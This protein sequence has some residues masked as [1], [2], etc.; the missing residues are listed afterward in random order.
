MKCITIS[1]DTLN[2][3]DSVVGL[4]LLAAG[5]SVP[6]AVS[7]VIVTKQGHGAM[8]ISN[9]IGSNTFD[10]L[11]C[12]GIPW[13]I[14]AYFFPAIVDNKWVVINSTGLS[15]STISLLSSLLALYFTL[16]V[17]KF[18]LDWKVGLVC[19]LLYTVF[20]ILASLIELNF[21]FQVNL[22]VCPH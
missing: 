10:I 20:L 16:A 7:S 11:L 1:G 14:K 22:P 5:T 17:N 13:V 15:Y 18:R 12:L 21:F 9:S 4:T 2:I 6:E 8:G 19:A 3:P